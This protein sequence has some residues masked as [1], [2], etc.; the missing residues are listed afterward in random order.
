MGNLAA[1]EALALRWTELENDPALRTLPYKVELNLWGKLEM[2][3]AS[4][5]HARVQGA[6]AGQ[7]AQQLPDGEVLTE[8]PILTD[9]GVR[10]PDVAWASRQFLERY[11]EASP[12]P[13]APEICIEIVSPSNTEDEIRDKIRA[14]LAAG[15]KEVWIVAEAGSVRFFDAAGERAQSAFPVKLLLPGSLPKS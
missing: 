4:F 12:S 10:V 6:V 13:S 7:L 2:T 11:G 15:A 1:P 14:Y 9:I 8:V 5:R 3:P